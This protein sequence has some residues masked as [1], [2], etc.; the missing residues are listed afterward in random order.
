MCPVHVL[1][2]VLIYLSILVYIYVSNYV[3]L[4]FNIRMYPFNLFYKLNLHNLVL[5]PYSSHNIFHL[6]Y[7]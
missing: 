5:S 3:H 4:S 2:S 1:T 6:I 7:H